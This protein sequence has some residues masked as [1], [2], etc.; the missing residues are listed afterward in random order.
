MYNTV[1]K[2]T[3]K[4]KRDEKQKLWMFKNK[5]V[6]LD[7]HMQAAIVSLKRSLLGT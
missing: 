2:Q 1:N 5:R 7:Q 3:N 6:E 4:Q